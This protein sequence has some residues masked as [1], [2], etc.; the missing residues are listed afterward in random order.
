MGCLTLSPHV[1]KLLDSRIKI[2]FHPHQIRKNALF[3]QPK[4]VNKIN[5][6]QVT[7]H[8]LEKPNDW[9][10]LHLPLVIPLKFGQDS[11]HTS[12][13]RPTFLHRKRERERGPKAPRKPGHTLH[14][15]TCSIH[16]SRGALQRASRAGASPQRVVKQRP[17]T[18]DVRPNQGQTSTITKNSPT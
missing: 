4:I 6:K 10:K 15:R 8:T 7:N 3:S 5:Q 13:G 16:H 14:T 2:F 11:C 18:M 17:T 1:T 12:K 9:W